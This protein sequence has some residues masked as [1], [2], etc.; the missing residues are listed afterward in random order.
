MRFVILIMVAS[1]AAF[2][3]C[4]RAEVQSQNAEQAVSMQVAVPTPV[5][6]PTSAIP[7]LQAELLDER[8][9]IST[10]PIAKFDF[11]NYTYELPRG[12]QNPDGTTEITLTDGRVEPREANPGVGKNDSAKSKNKESSKEKE[13]GTEADSASLRRIGLM[14]VA[15]KFFDVTGD[16]DDEAVVVLKIETGGTAIP[17]I[18]HIFSWKDGKPVLVW[19]FRTGDRADG[20]LKNI[21]AEGGNLVVELYGQDRFLLGQTETGRIGDDLEQLCCPT[22]FTRTVYKW[23]GKNFLLQGKRLTYLTSNPTAAPQENLGDAAQKP[24][25]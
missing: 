8:N 2:S 7:N 23:N 22:H 1:L 20:G 13:N 3:S 4:R 14:L 12:W 18:V 17:Q 5:P 10:S 6:S 9:T 15:T 11:K 25:R 21:F 16:G 19:P 24:K